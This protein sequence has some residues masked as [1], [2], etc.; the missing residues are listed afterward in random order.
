MHIDLFGELLAKQM[1]RKE[2]L[3]HLGIL[4]L[5]LTGI[6]G[7]LKTLS[8]PHVVNKHIRPNT[9]FGAGRYGG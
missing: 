2:F 9:G 4:L 6:S 5:A 3:V 1:T 7:V 8:D